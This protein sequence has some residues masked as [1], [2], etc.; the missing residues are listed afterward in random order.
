MEAGWCTIVCDK[1]TVSGTQSENNKINKPHG[2]GRMI[3]GRHRGQVEE[4]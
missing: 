3:A 2:M 1:G 4:A